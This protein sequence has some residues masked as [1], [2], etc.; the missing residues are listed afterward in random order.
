LLDKSKHRTILLSLLKSIYTD[1]KIS[2]ILGFKGGT[3]LYLF[4]ELPRFSVDLDFDLLNLNSEELVFDS[5]ES[6]SKKYCEVKTAIKKRNSIQFLLSYDKNSQNIK[7]DISKRNFGASYELKN[8]AG[9]SMNVMKKE[10][11]FANKLIALTE[12]PNLA[13]RDLFDLEYMFKKL[14]NIN[15]EIIISR[16]KLGLEQY[17]RKAIDLV[18]NYKFDNILSEI[19]E[20][21]DDKQKIWVK[22]KLQQECVFAMKIRLDCLEKEF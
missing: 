14:W 20:L 5:I 2:S 1:V 11:L 7:L 13:V 3:A 6:I 19:G 9:L 4:Y 17:L 22:K 21:L 10:D 15:E 16:S 12:R 18:E 8:V